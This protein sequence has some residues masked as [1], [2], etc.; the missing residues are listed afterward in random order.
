MDVGRLRDRVTF[1]QRSTVKDAYN[2]ASSDWEDVL[3]SF[4]AEVSDLQG[5]ELIKAQI[6]SAEATVKIVMRGFTGWRT[7]IVPQMR[8]CFGTRHFDIK[9]VLNPDNRGVILNI[10]AKEI[11]R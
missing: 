6:I 10:L 8:A 9:S 4:P 2:Q 1:Q 11:V 7:Q 5:S 3:Q